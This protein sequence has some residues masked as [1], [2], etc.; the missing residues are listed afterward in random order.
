MAIVMMIVTIASSDSETVLVRGKG[1]IK[2]IIFRQIFNKTVFKKLKWT[3]SRFAIV[4]CLAN[5][6]TLWQR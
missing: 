5:L 3:K 6:S 2:W 4:Q 1:L